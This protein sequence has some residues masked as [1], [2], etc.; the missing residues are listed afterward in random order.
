MSDALVGMLIAVLQVA[1]VLVV[2]V[3]WLNGL[4]NKK[5][6]LRARKI[7]WFLTG[8]FMLWLAWGQYEERAMGMVV[9]IVLLGIVTIIGSF[10]L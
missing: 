1:A 9:F 4:F 10:I 5:V 3:G 7:V 8:I 6:P 2:F